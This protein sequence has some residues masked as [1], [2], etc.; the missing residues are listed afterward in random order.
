MASA[1]G[2]SSAGATGVG[3]KSGS[4]SQNASGAGD[5][6]ARKDSGGSIE[7]HGIKNSNAGAATSSASSSGI[8]CVSSTSRVQGGKAD[9]ALANDYTSPD[10]N[11]HSGLG[12]SSLRKSQLEIDKDNMETSDGGRVVDSE[13]NESNIHTDENSLAAGDSSSGTSSASQQPAGDIEVV[14]SDGDEN[15]EDNSGAT[16]AAAGTSTTGTVG[17]NN[18]NA[19]VE[20]AN[21]DEEEAVKVTGNIDLDHEGDEIEMVQDDDDEIEMAQD[22]DDE[23]EIAQEEEEVEMAQEEEEVEAEGG[24]EDEPEDDDQYET[25]HYNRFD[26]VLMYYHLT[27]RSCVDMVSASESCLNF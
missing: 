7:D 16:E 1:A 5:D 9:G 4:S 27:F 17:A 18:A 21:I 15:K 14:S 13:E 8:C 19:D 22:D 3:S 26:D 2:T 20:L 25:S 24:L 6:D 11:A 23:I 12:N 10:S